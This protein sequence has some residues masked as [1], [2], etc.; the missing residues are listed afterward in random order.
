MGAL[1]PRP[2]DLDRLLRL[3]LGALRT[4]GL[5]HVALGALALRHD[6]RLGMVSRIPSAAPCL[7][8][9]S[10]V[11]YRCGDSRA[12]PSVTS[13]GYR[14]HRESCTGLGTVGRSTDSGGVARWWQTQSSS[15]TVSTS[16][17]TIATPAADRLGRPSL[18]LKPTSLALREPTHRAECAWR[19]LRVGSR[20]AA[21]CQWCLA[22]PARAACCLSLRAAFAYPRRELGAE[23]LCHSCGMAR[24]G[25]RSMISASSCVR[26]WMTFSAGTTRDPPQSR[27]APARAQVRFGPLRHAQQGQQGHRQGGSKP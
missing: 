22:E 25:C 11:V 9:R 10:R 1:P 14:W 26:R 8:T 19:S 24:R 18:T 17:P 13:V 5:G 16:S 2:L 21:P 12:R 7:A 6:L 23:H 4:V 3:E 15:T 20:Y 27:P